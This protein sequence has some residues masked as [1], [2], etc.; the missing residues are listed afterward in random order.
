MLDVSEATVRRYLRKGILT[1]STER[2]SLSVQTPGLL[3]A[4]KEKLRR[5]GVVSSDAGV[6]D[7]ERIRDLES[8][9][10]TLTEVVR[11]LRMADQLLLDSIGALTPMQVPT[12]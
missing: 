10:E 4:Q 3:A 12:K 6:R 11:N 5:M 7:A 8:Q 9:V 1:A 2:G